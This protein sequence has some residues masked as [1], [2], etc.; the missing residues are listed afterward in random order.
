M[1]N[2]NYTMKYRQGGFSIGEVLIG[3]LVFA[4]GM[5]A[6][7][8]LQTSL[9][10]AQAEAH[11]RAVASG[12][13][14]R[15]IERSMGFSDLG[16]ADGTPTAG[17][18]TYVEI[19]PANI[20]NQIVAAGG[21][22]VGANS[23]RVEIPVGGVQYTITPTVTDYYFNNE[24]TPAA[25]TTAA[26]TGAE[27]SDFKQLD[28]QVT[29]T[30]ADFG[31][32]GRLGSGVVN[33]GSVISSVTSPTST[34]VQNSSNTALLPPIEYTPG[35]NPDI[36]SLNLGSSR[37][38]ESTLPEP[39]I[40][41]DKGETT[42][43]VVTYATNANNQSSF[44]RREEFRAVSCACEFAGTDTRPE[45]VYWAGDVYLLGDSVESKVTGVNVDSRGQSTINS[46]LC[47]RCCENHHDKVGSNG[48][49]YRRYRPF[50]DDYA[51]SGNHKHYNVD[52]DGNLFEVLEVAGNEYLEACRMVR[53]NGFWQVAQ[54]LRDE[55]RFIVPGD[56]L[57]DDAELQTYS[58]YIVGSG[59]DATRD[60]AVELFFDE[61]S[62]T[63]SGYPASM[64]CW[65]NLPGCAA[66]LSGPIYSPGYNAAR[67]AGKFPSWVGVQ[68]PNGSDQLR[69]RGLYIDF[70]HPD[71]QDLMK[72][73]EGNTD[74]DNLPCKVSGT[75]G[76]GVAVVDLFETANSPE[77]MPFFEVQLT[78]LTP[79]SSVSP[80]EVSNDPIGSRNFSRGLATTNGLGNGEAMVRFRQGNL[81]L[82]DVTAHLPEIN[83]TSGNE[84]APVLTASLDVRGV[85]GSGDGGGGGDPMGTVI[86]GSVSALDLAYKYSLGSVSAESAEG[87]SINS[88]AWTC[89]V[90]D[91]AAT[92]APTF[93]VELINTDA[94]S[95]ATYYLCDL[96]NELT[97]TNTST[98]AGTTSATIAL[99]VGSNPP[100]SLIQNLQVRATSCT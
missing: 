58:N 35:A 32:D 77:I 34:K 30:G 95:V 66:G 26:P 80:I 61:I 68:N 84:V 1:K 37:F 94:A 43:D 42:W 59:G 83:A 100:A 81:G 17:A 45:P 11:N 79:W 31:G 24:V 63:T 54:D 55:Q 53:V 3:I 85:D 90:A 12:I 56:W 62:R 21:T 33:L 91:F 27:Y 36:V 89:T 51:A 22:A 49:G 2:A 23:V 16:N 15:I 14:E 71:L 92:P 60:G 86:S 57:D 73:L 93:T 4:V 9:T 88:G 72:C 8:A 10:R 50:D 65:A 75:P 69:S 6:L 40:N 38:K 19:T 87:C 18:F 5:L 46:R 97:I 25:F 47:D 28:V 78:S 44:L 13:A 41:K 99:S 70:M 82:L 52:R 98:V 96:S 29:W 20:I 64:P 76:V 39:R 48:A 67:D 7:G 74:F